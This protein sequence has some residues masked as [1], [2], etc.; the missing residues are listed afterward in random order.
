VARNLGL[1]YYEFT[2]TDA[3]QP[4]ELLWSVDTVRRFNDAQLGR[5]GAVGRENA[6]NE[7][8]EPGPLWW[9]L[10]PETAGRRGAPPEQGSVP[11]ARPPAQLP[12]HTPTRPG[13]VLLIDEIDKA[14]SS[15]CNGL[16]VPLGSR[17]FFVPVIDT[18]VVAAEAQVPGSPLVLITTNNERDLPEAFIRRCV[19]LSIAAPTD[20]KLIEIALRHF[21][22]SAESPVTRQ[23]IATLAKR[24]AGDERQD[25]AARQPSTAEFLDLIRTLLDLKLDID[26]DE[27]GIVEQLIVEKRDVRGSRVLEW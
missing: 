4:Q 23:Q 12:G 10:N 24:M 1:A 26:G 20:E 19:A 5:L 8:V 21:G 25:Q 15:F 27:W 2:V 6:L 9:C 11:D 16:L 13:A 17:Q 22:E 14:D 7:Y 3:A 18:L